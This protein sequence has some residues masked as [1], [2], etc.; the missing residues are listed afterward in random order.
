MDSNFTVLQSICNVLFEIHLYQGLG[1][2]C[3]A[4]NVESGHSTTSS[5]SLSLLGKL[6]FT[7]LGFPLPKVMVVVITLMR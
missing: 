3:D 2:L 5:L 4:L 1:L 6:P 7:G